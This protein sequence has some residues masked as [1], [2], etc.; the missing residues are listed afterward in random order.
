MNI[1]K[2]EAF[3]RAVELGSLSKAAEELGYT[4]SGISHMMQSL[5]DEV[6]FP[7][8]VRTSSGIVPNHEGE[9]LLPIIR[10]LLNTNEALGQY[11]AK[12]KGADTGRIR[13]AAY[14]SV[15]TYWLPGIIRDFQKDYPNVEI[16][17]T[18]AGSNVIEEIMSSR[19]AELCIYAGGENKGFEWVPLCEDRML[20]LVPPGHPLAA[21]PSVPLEAFLKE[22]FIMPTPGYDG[23]VRYILD[24]LPHWPHILF[25]ACSD[26]AIINMVAQG[27]GV[28]ILPELQLA[29]YAHSAVALPMDP[30]QERMLG[31]GVPQIKTASP[32]T[33]NFMD[34]VRAYA[35]RL[36]ISG[37]AGR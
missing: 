25:S 15:A 30:P 12:I 31:M 3:V 26:Y 17:I 5:E 10:Q 18:E 13:I 6:G 9:M 36:K 2:Y 4:Q 8:M 14:S 11:I 20:A 24:K 19:Q 16:E 37:E 33:R 28:S 22:Q 34:Y 7:L 27:L 23:E 32:V 35:E 29:N 1:R 21:G